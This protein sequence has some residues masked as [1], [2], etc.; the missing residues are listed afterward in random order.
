MDGAVYVCGY[1]IEIMLKARICF[2]QSWPS[3]PETSA[4]FR[5]CP[6]AVRSHDFDFL[7]NQTDIEAKIKSGYFKEWSI[8]RVWL[9]DLRYRVTGTTMQAEAAEMVAAARTLLGVM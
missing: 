7:L 5:S 1:A 4:E 6:I 8:V 9:S 3:F 2:A